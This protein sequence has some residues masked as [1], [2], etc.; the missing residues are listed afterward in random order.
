MVVGS[1]LYIK[2]VK[3]VPVIVVVV[4]YRSVWLSIYF[5]EKSVIIMMRVIFLVSLFSLSIRLMV[6]VM[7]IIYR[8]VRLKDSRGDKVRRLFSG[9]VI[10]S[11]CVL[12]VYMVIVMRI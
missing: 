4:M 11:I 8:V 2:N 10:Y 7:V 5:R 3:R 6:L 1:K 9:F 12:R